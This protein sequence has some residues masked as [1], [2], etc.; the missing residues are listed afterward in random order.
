MQSA[1]SEII[2]ASETIIFDSVVF[3]P[4]TLPA[5]Q[6]VKPRTAAPGK[7]LIRTLLLKWDMIAV[8]TF[9]LASAVYGMYALCFLTGF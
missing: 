1:A 4:D 2:I 3:L 5:V 8:V 7:A 6:I 9:M